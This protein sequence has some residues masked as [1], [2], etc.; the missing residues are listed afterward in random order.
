[1]VSQESGSRLWKLFES[2]ILVILGFLLGIIGSYF[3]HSYERREQRQSLALALS[4]C[5][6]FEI[7]LAQLTEEQVKAGKFMYSNEML[8][9][10]SLFYD[11]RPKVTILEKKIISQVIAFNAA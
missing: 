8:H 2:V 7:K 3:M 1:M 9:N 5:V 10:P 4:E 11:L 6:R